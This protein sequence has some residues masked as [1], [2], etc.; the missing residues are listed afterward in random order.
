MPTAIDF[1]KYSK[2]HV[3]G[4]WTSAGA[5][6]NRLYLAEASGVVAAS[7]G[8][9]RVGGTTVILNSS[10]SEVYH[11]LTGDYDVSSYTGNYCIYITMSDSS[12]SD[13]ASTY[14]WELY[15]EE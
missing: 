2:L 1:T 5:G 10:T 4:Y 12:T 6:T 13:W 14:I 7:G 8:T 11:A 3:S 15:V 9:Y